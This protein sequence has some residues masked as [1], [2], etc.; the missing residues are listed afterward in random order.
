MDSLVIAIVGYCITLSMAKIF[1]IK[2]NYKISGSQEMLAEGAGN[3]V[4][5]WFSCLPASASMSR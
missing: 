5:C 4:G 1:A 2:F 3:L